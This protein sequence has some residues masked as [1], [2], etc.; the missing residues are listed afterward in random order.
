MIGLFIAI[1][2][3]IHFFIEAKKRGASSFKWAAI[4]F[5]TFMGTQFIF[6]WIIVPILIVIFP[7][8]PDKIH[9]I[10]VP[11][12]IIGVAVG[13]YLLVYSRKKLYRIPR[14]VEDSDLQ[15]ITSLEIIKN[16]DGSFS[17]ADRSFKSKRDAEDYV[18][19]LKRTTE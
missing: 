2:A 11:V 16:S 3:C 14:L 19:L 18:S 10:I 1:V 12:N 9:R 5:G 17:V 6:A 13:F 4:A 7:M 15:V 8:S